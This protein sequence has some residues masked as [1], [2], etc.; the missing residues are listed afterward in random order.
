MWII[1]IFFVA[2][3]TCQM[4]FAQSQVADEISSDTINVIQS[5]VQQDST[6]LTESA[7]TFE[8]MLQGVTEIKSLSTKESSFE[9][10]IGFILKGDVF[11]YFNLN[12]QYYTPLEKEN[13]KKTD[14]YKEYYS[15][16]NEMKMN[17]K[18]G[19]F[20]AKEKRSY[21][22]YDLKKKGFKWDLGQDLSVVYD[23]QARRMAGNSCQKADINGC[24]GM[25]FDDGG[26][27][28]QIV[29]KNLCQ[30]RAIFLPVDETIGASV[31][32]DNDAKLY[33]IFSNPVITKISSAMENTVLAVTLQEV[34]LANS[35]GTVYATKKYN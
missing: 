24:N 17:L 7:M 32:S 35:S 8:K 13:F 27:G 34:V 11:G 25:E 19:K 26:N 6:T 20:Y 1:T 4:V 33:F 14:T 2:G 10:S 31:E 9:E 23:C 28:F 3:L 29:F 15:T 18:T 12:D 22:E 30:S 16:L 5:N 21:H